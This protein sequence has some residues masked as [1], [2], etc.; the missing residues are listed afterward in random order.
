MCI[1]ISWGKW[2]HKIIE[3]EDFGRPYFYLTHFGVNVLQTENWCTF[4][5]SHLHLHLIDDFLVWV[6]VASFCGMRRCKRLVIKWHGD[7]ESNTITIPPCP[8]PSIIF[9]PWFSYQ[10]GH[11]DSVWLRNFHISQRLRITAALANKVSRNLS[12]RQFRSCQD[13]GH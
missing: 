7:T 13:H 8:S 2:W 4:L 5:S 6:A 3:S 11:L 1:A 12:A 10:S 9:F